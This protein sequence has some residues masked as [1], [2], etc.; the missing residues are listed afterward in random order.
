MDINDTLDYIFRVEREFEDW[1]RKYKES[2]DHR[3]FL[4]YVFMSER[5]KT[6]V[7][8]NLNSISVY[9]DE[10]KSKLGEFFESKDLP[11]HIDTAVKYI[12]EIKSELRNIVHMYNEQQDYTKIRNEWGIVLLKILKLTRDLRGRLLIIKRIIE[13]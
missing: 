4:S 6:L 12:D 10:L 9:L 11:F 13:K 1:D 3:W 7:K 5:I 2:K 8:D